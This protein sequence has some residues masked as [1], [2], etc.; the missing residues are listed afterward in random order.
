MRQMI[1][2]AAIVALSPR[3]LV[4]DEPTTGLDATGTSL[5]MDLI[6]RLHCNGTAI[7]LITHDLSLATRYASRLV[8]MGQGEILLDDPMEKGLEK[9]DVLQRA[10]LIPDT[11]E[12]FSAKTGGL[13]D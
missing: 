7:I 13:H 9:T 3:L 11:L 1:A 8:V 5:I 4:V 12:S 2:V 6:Q 10:G